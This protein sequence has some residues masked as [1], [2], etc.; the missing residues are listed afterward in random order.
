MYDGAQGVLHFCNTVIA[1][2]GDLKKLK[3][4]LLVNQ[5]KWYIETPPAL[6]YSPLMDFFMKLTQSVNFHNI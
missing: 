3:T 2:L 1:F 4:T 5:K 6:L